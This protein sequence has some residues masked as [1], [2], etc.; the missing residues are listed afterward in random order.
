MSWLD[1]RSPKFGADLAH[2]FAVPVVSDD[3]ESGSEKA[4]PTP[5]A[6]TNHPSN[7]K[8]LEK[9][10]EHPIEGAWAE[11]KN[12]YIIF[13][14]K[15]FPWIKSVLTHGT[16]IDIHAEQMGKEGSAHHARMEKMHA[17]AKQYPNE[18]EH[19]YSFVQVLTACTASFAHGANDVSSA[20]LFTEGES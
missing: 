11:P 3:G 15:A 7:L 10:D 20:C 6:A 18:V 19:M 14:Y 5:A 9:V 17:A 13:R 12:L 2:S 4:H 8:E 1:S 16:S